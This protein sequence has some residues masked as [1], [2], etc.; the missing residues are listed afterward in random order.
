V[1]PVK[2]I[3]Y[4]PIVIKLLAWHNQLLIWKAEFSFFIEVKFMR[5][6]VFVDGANFL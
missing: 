3:F 4:N 5:I 6:A 1:I 2:R